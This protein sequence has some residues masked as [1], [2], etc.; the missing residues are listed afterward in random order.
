MQPRAQGGPHT[1]ANL[2]SLWGGHHDAVHTGRLRIA[3]A[4]SGE[5]TF[6]H[7]DGR[8]DGMPTTKPTRHRAGRSSAV[9]PRS[10]AQ[11]GPLGDVEQALR[12][13]GFSAAK[14]RAAAAACASHI[15]Q[16]LEDLVRRALR[17]AHEP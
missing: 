15:G 1:M 7:A 4:A 14:A 2:I 13:L 8:S 9:P 16:P 12:G 11:D 10:G 3:R 5:P 17:A 6:T